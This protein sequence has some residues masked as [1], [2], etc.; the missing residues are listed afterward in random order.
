MPSV[1]FSLRMDTKIKKALEAQAKLEKRSA[2]FVL[3]Q[4]AIDYIERQK[5]IRALVSSLKVEAKKGEFISDEAMTAWVLSLGTENELPDPEPD[6]FV[7][8]HKL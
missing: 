6:V 1:P 3:Q 7:K 8:S 2:G 4:A 5:R